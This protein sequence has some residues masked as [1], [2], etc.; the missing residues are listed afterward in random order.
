MVRRLSLIPVLAGF[1]VL[2]A[3][4]A[5]CGSSGSSSTSSS[6]TATS[7]SS[8]GGSYGS[9]ATSTASSSGGGAATVDVAD[10]SE[11]G[12]ILSDADGK[13]VYYFLKDKNGK[14]SCNGACAA[15]WP[16]FMTQGQPQAGSGVT[17]SKLTT[18]KR[19]DGSTQVV[20]NGWPLYYYAGDK[21]PG[22]TTGNELDQFG[23]EWYAI[24]PAGEEPK[25][26]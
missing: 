21:A 25:G 18:T 5:G 22:D 19:S 9:A 1:A 6:G 26:S 3:L 14:S 17:A 15:A 16:P 13:T 20:Y 23:A 7:A 2:G 11:L 8:S 10:N 4:L 24:T 12:K